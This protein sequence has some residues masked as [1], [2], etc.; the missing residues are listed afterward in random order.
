MD[1]SI[2]GIQSTTLAVTAALT[3][4][5]LVAGALIIAFLILSLI[6]I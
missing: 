5:V 2:F 3:A 6:H 1:F 4:V